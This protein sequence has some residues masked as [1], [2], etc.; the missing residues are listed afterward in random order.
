MGRTPSPT[1]FPTAAPTPSPTIARTPNP[2]T[3]PTPKPIQQEQQ[4]EKVVRR[5][6]TETKDQAQSPINNSTK[7]S[8]NNS[9]IP[10]PGPD[11]TYD[12]S[13][14]NL[15]VIGNCGWHKC[16]FPSR[17]NHTVG[18]LV[19][20][21]RE[22]NKLKMSDDV[23]RDLSQRFG[24]KH[25][26]LALHKDRVSYEFQDYINSIVFNPMLAMRGMEQ[27]PVLSNHTQH[28]AI[29]KVIVAP[30]PSFWFAIMKNN[31]NLMKTHLNEFYPKILDREAFAEQMYKEY[32]RLVKILDYKPGFVRDFQGLI[33]VHGN[34]YYIDLDGHLHLQSHPIESFEVPNA[35]R[36]FLQLIKNFT[37]GGEM[38]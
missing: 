1:N 8:N 20:S 2:T 11:S 23:A 25:F 21:G 10:S 9:S 27:R 17:S 29:Q 30:E 24:A 33:D 4:E 5:K 28:I 18:Y 38:E 15:S 16:F 32:D 31:Y 35:K 34:F 26:N 6:T 13:D 14:V 12:W 22:H 36:T 3:A 7:T 19:V 37:V